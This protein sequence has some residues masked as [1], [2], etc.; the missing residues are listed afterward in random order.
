MFPSSDS[1]KQR[2]FDDDSYAA[3][4][5]GASDNID[6]SEAVSVTQVHSSEQSASSTSTPLAVLVATSNALGITIYQPAYG[7]RSLRRSI[8]SS[9]TVPPAGGVSTSGPIRFDIVSLLDCS[10]QSHCKYLLFP[11]HPNKATFLG[12]L[13]EVIALTIAQFPSH[14]TKLH[15]VTMLQVGL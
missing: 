1:R 6:L 14:T 12:K 2:A 10:S 13:G 3:V 11:Y 4:G 7:W 5:A 9:V 15:D 8:N